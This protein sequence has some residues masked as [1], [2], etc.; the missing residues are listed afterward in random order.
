[1]ARKLG[2]GLANV[3][4][5]LLEIPRQMMRT[6]EQEGIIAGLTVGMVKGVGWAVSRELVGIYEVVTFVAPQ[7][8]EYG[9]ILEPE[10]VYSHQE[11]Q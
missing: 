3:T 7:P 6:L 1:M 9:V 11:W 5:G 2:R 8:N 10:F 4:T